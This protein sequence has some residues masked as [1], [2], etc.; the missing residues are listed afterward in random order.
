MLKAT[1]FRERARNTLEGKWAIAVLVCFLGLLLGGIMTQKLVEITYQNDVGWQ[2]QLMQYFKIDLDFLALNPVFG[3]MIATLVGILTIWGIAQFII[4]GAV[5][6]GICKY[7]MKL[8]CRQEGEVA[9]EFSY[10]NYLLN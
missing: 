3:V 9:D 1:D 2:L 8:A 7:F 10:F 4:G 5:E 6:L